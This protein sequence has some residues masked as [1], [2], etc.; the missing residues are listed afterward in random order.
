MK[1]AIRAIALCTF[2]VGPLFASAQTVV[3]I[4]PKPCQWGLWGSYFLTPQKGFVVG[5]MK[6]LYRTLD[7]GTTWTKASL[8]GDQSIPLYSVNFLDTNVGIVTGNS[9]PPAPDIYRTTNGGA[10][11]TAV[12]GFPLG[13][14]WYEQDYTSATTGFIGSNGAIVRTTNAGA[15]WSLRSFYP[16]CPSIIGMDFLDA[17]TGFVTGGLPTYET[18]IFKTT[19]GGVTWQLKRP[20]GA[21]DVIY[22]SPTVLLAEVGDGIARSGDGG[23]SWLMINTSVTTGLTD[24][25]KVDSQTVVGVSGRGDIWRTTDGGFSWE[26]KWIGEGDLPGNWSVKFSSP[27]LG[28]VVGVRGLTYMT[29]DGGATWTRVGRGAAVEGNGLAVLK[30]EVVVT[31]GHHGIAQRLPQTGPWDVSLID[32][33]TFGRDTSYSAVSGVGD[34]LYAVGHWGGMARS[35]DGGRTWQNLA[36]VVS[37]DFYANDVKFVDPMNGWMTGWDYSTGAPQETFRTYDGGMSWQVVPSGNFPGVALEVRGSRVWIQS[38]GQVQWRS[39]NGGASF[40]AVQLPY[41]SGSTPSVA[42]V[43]FATNDIGYVSGYDGYLVKTLNGGATWTQVGSMTYNIHNLNVLAYGNELWVCGARAGG[44]SAYVRRSTNQGQTWQTW[45]FGGQYTT[46]YRMARTQKHLY[47]SGYNGETW[48]I[49]GLGK[50]P[51]PTR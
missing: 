16:T 21:N 1:A 45:N 36:G 9:G 11:W 51:L 27:L 15:S 4:A 38:G 25:E 14:S 43:S 20:G 19:D 18:G 31:V 30:D 39:T 32:P 8:P 34:F 23:E 7:G 35:F 49:D 28:T 5:G 46:P 3:Q 6:S 41:N 44:G 22:L 40:S 26:Q 13:G 37:F 24:L 48:R 47:L 42:A 10:T 2:A 29:Q 17:N 50:V 12:A 33:P